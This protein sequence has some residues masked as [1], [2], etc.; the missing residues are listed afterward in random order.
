LKEYDF[1]H[2]GYATKYEQIGFEPLTGETLQRLV[3]VKRLDE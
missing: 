3:L 1:A 2:I